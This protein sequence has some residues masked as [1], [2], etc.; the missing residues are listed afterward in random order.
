MMMISA[1]FIVLFNP[2]ILCFIALRLSLD[3]YVALCDIWNRRRSFFLSF[4]YI[5]WKYLFFPSSCSFFL[6]FLLLLHHHI[7]FLVMCLDIETHAN[8]VL[9]SLW[10]FHE[11]SFDFIWNIF[12]DYFWINFSLLDRKLNF[13]LN[14]SSGVFNPRGF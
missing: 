8:R 7:F 11:S 3:G 5:E 1:G 12:F 14:F 2:K 13:W 9:F 6:Q 10:S 4:S